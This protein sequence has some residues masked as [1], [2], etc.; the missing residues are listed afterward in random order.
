MLKKIRLKK[1]NKIGF[2]EKLS[3]KYIFYGDFS[4][5]YADFSKC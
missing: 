3:L 1:Y 2:L 4:L 5:T